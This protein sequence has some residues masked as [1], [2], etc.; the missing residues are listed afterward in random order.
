MF[1][2][3]RDGT[4]E[5]FDWNKIDTVI[6]KAFHSV[7]AHLNEDIL[8]DIKDQLYIQPFMTVEDIQDQIEDAL[9]ECGYQTVGKAF[10]RY[11]DQHKDSR[12]LLDRL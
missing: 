9:F 12:E 7:D 1:I 3:K 11:R 8:S 2:V 10:I 5:T 4:L 6:T